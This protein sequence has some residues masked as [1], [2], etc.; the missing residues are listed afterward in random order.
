[1]TPDELA[2]VVKAWRGSTSQREAAEFLRMNQRTFENLEQGRK[3][4]VHPALLVTAMDVLAVQYPGKFN[5]L[6]ASALA[7]SVG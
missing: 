7:A 1:M 2:A 5:P 4:F 6:P 3:R